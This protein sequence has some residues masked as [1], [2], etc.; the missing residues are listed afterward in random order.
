MSGH[1][2]KNSAPAIA[3]PLR[4]L[5]TSSLA[6]SVVLHCRVPNGVKNRKRREHPEL[7]IPLG[8]AVS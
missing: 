1:C 8:F 3:K 4:T 7:R 6:P 5:S 2:A